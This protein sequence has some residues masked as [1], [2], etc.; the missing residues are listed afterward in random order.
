M[1]IVNLVKSELIKNYSIKKLIIISV[2]MLVVSIGF[3]EIYS[4]MYEKSVWSFSNFQKKIEE[5]S[6]KENRTLEEDYN[7]MV[8]EVKGKIYTYL[9]SLEIQG[10]DYA[11][12]LA[13]EMIRLSST[14]IG[15]K[16]LKENYDSSTIQ[17][18]CNT[19][20]YIFESPFQ[21][22]IH[23]LCTAYPKPELDTLYLENEEKINDYANILKSNKY[24]VY[25]E[26]LL[27]KGLI[28]EEEKEIANFIILNKVENSNHYL[29]LNLNQYRQLGLHANQELIKEA[30]F[31]PK[32][33]NNSF[34]TY[35]DYVRYYT[36]LKEE[37]ISKRNIILYSQEHSIPHDLAFNSDDQ[38]DD[39]DIYLTTKS[40][41]NLIFHFSVIVM[42]LVS[43]TSG[44]IIAG[45]HS[46]GTIK[47]IIT[48]PVRRC[49][50]L[51]SKFIYL[52]LHTYI[53]W[54]IGLLF[55]SL[56]SGMKYGFTDLFTPKLLYMNHHVVEVNYYLY[57]LKE[58]FVASIPV[59]CFLS[60][61]FFLSAITLSTSI[62]VG[63]TSI[64]AILS[65][66]YWF[67]CAN[68]KCRF[69]I[70]TPF[71]FFDVG[72]IHSKLEPY[73]NILKQANISYGRGIIISIVVTIILYGITNIVYTKRDI[74]N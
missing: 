19:S 66:I 32:N 10:N 70:Y 41:V 61:L 34:P 37:A 21:G 8:Y 33:Y 59:I 30:E 17:Q 53:I 26:Y 12:D 5:L 67:L 35:Q 54:L 1:K 62:T 64:L 6:N 2:I 68:L 24:Y 69:L 36:Y 72:F 29:V 51:L 63:I 14:N 57:L 43:I 39:Y 23:H 27:N 60:I 44:N 11:R 47:N 13:E 74:K 38:I 65:P 56:Y 18:I 28:P 55:L 71:L 31:K 3:V 58:L 46:K 25:M 20:S 49:K 7:L 40:N 9:N 45:E 42:V 48:A 15:I 73:T 16:I 52:I 4:K 50:I 22:E